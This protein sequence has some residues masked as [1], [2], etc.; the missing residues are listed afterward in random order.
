MA[1]L[2]VI[3]AVFLLYPVVDICRLSF[4][5]D[6]VFTLQNYRGLF[7]RTPDLPLLLQQHVRIH[8]DHG[9]HHGAGLPVCLWSHPHHHARQRV[10]LHGIHPAP[11]C[12]DHHPGPGAH[13]AVRSQRRHYT[14]PSGTRAGISTA[15]PGSS[16]ERFSTVFPMPFSSFIPRCPLWTRAST[17]PRKASAPPR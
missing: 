13:S 11:H 10:F 12:A 1:F 16:W 8:G 14:L 2:L 7:L 3:L 17:K 9:H 4:F 15:P 5:K 6:G